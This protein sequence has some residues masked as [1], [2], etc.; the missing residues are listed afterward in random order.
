[1]RIHLPLI[2]RAFITKP[3]ISY[4][5]KFTPKW[6]NW[7]IFYQIRK[8]EENQLIFSKKASLDLHNDHI[9]N[10]SEKY[11]TMYNFF[12]EKYMSYKEFLVLQLY[13]LAYEPHPF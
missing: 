10:K 8:Y 6:W 2:V 12:S 7:V 5:P 3:F 1:M 13:N 11:S 9:R 4:T